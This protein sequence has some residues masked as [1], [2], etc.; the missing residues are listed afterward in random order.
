MAT[1]SHEGGSPDTIVS[2]LYCLFLRFA[3][4]ANRSNVIRTE[5]KVW[6]QIEHGL[7]TDDINSRSQA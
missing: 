2:V 1:R 4:L 3:R 5:G 7:N 6:P